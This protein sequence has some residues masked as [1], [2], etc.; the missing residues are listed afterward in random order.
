MNVSIIINGVR[1]DSVESIS[2]EYFCDSC[3]LLRNPIIYKEV[4]VK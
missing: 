1:Y 2:V 3:D 4:E